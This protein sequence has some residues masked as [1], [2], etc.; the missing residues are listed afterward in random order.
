M[1]KKISVVVPIYNCIKYLN[2]AVDSLINQSYK[3]LEILL[4]DD[5]STDGSS[6]L[7]D[8]LASRYGNIFVYH[9]ENGGLSTARNLGV[10]KAT[11]E[12]IGFV[13]ADD[14]INPNTYKYM[15][16]LMK[17]HNADVVEVGMYQAPSYFIK[18]NKKIGKIDVVEQDDIIS[19]YLQF[20]LR[21]GDYSFCCCLFDKALF[22][23]YS[24]R[25]GKINTDLDDKYRILSK[26]KKYVV[27]SQKHYYYFQNPSS[28]TRNGL[29]NRDFNIFISID[30]LKEL[31]QNENEN[32]KKLVQIKEARTHFSILAKIA[33]FGFCDEFNEKEVI[34]EQ[35]GLL[36]QN[37]ILLMRSNI[38]LSR[39][40]MITLM[41]LDYYVFA[42]LIRLYRKV[43]KK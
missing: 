4:I 16:G 28:L 5:G 32:I 34:Q 7:C 18:E 8:K 31:T 13:D 36:R 10:S 33:Y 3:N 21:T 2:R 38:S 27:S 29:K 20:M 15:T 14:W 39:K 11:G 40:L 37:Y 43:T 1:N 23:N 24:F 22:E 25:E 19:Y 42:A 9:K 30:K 17:E 6:E 12:L 41:S 26:S 35:L